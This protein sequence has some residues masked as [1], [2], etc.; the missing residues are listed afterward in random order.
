VNRPITK[1]ASLSMGRLRATLLLVCILALSGCTTF[2]PP[3]ISYDAD[4]PPLPDP[5]L[6]AEDRPRPLHVPP[7]WTPA[8]GSK[9]GAKEAEEPVARIETAN[10]AARVEPRKEGTS[11]PC[12]CFRLVPAPLSD[13]CALRTDHRYRARAR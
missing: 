6:L 9:K 1:I 4:V 2:K 8:K 13:L 12:R 5:P 11:T 10:D 7:S 3:Q